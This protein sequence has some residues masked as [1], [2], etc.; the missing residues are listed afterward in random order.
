MNIKNMCLLKGMI[1]L[2]IDLLGFICFLN[3]GF[4]SKYKNFY[5]ICFI[6]LY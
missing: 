2:N 3:D 6:L 5:Y 1:S 4:V